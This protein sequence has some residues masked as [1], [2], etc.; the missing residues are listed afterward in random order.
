M[1]HELQTSAFG[2]IGPLLNR[3]MQLPEV[4]SVIEENTQ[5][6]AILPRTSD[7]GLYHDGSAR[8]GSL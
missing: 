2:S 8:S 5:K 7:R 3:G 6:P 4:L 1:I